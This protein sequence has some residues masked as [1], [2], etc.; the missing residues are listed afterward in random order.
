[1]RTR[2]KSKVNSSIDKKSINENRV[3]ITSSNL[4]TQIQFRLRPILGTTLSCRKTSEQF[5]SLTKIPPTKP[6]NISSNRII[7]TV[8]SHQETLI[9]K[10]RSAV[11]EC[12]A[13]ILAKT[14]ITQSQAVEVFLKPNNTKS[15][16]NKERR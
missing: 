2:Y 11:S 12:N 5:I 3:K 8:D 6:R 16:E 14:E 1:M 15:T 9:D 7:P 10:I 13:Q 4:C